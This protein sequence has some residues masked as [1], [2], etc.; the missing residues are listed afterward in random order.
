VPTAIASSSIERVVMTDVTMPNGVSTSTSDTTGPR[1][2]SFTLP[3][4]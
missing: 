4:N 2:I 1:M 3:R